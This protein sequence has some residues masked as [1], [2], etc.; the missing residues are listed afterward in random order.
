MKK[1]I[2]AGGCFWGVEAYFKQL[3]GVIETSV[4]Y[5]DGDYENPSYDEVCSGMATHA[6]A[7]EI[8]YDDNV[9]S[10]NQL[11]EHLFRI[12]DPTS[13]NKQGPD[14]GHQYRTGIYFRGL[15]TLETIISFVKEEQKK[16]DDTIVV[17]VKAESHFSKAEE[18][19]QDYL[20]KNPGGYCHVDLNLATDDEKK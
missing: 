7:V 4:G 18:S 1:I 6:E 13:I 10:L 2:F 8:F 11:L 9:I 17:E 20:T 16:Y 15:D 14:S 3:I 19:H 5:V 12:I